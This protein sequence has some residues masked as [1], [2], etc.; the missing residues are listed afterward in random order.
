[1]LDEL[2]SAVLGMQA[3]AHDGWF[4]R[5][6]VEACQAMLTSSSTGRSVRL[7]TGLS[8]TST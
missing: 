1:M 7:S 2:S 5:A 8:T 3:P 6:A 4:G